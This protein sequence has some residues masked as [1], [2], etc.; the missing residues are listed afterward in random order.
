MQPLFHRVVLNAL[1]GVGL[2]IQKMS[3]HT[4]FRYVVHPLG[5]DLDLHPLLCRSRERAV[6]RLVAIGFGVMDPVPHTVGFRDIMAINNGIDPETFGR[7]LVAKFGVGHTLVAFHIKDDAHRVKVVYLVERDTLL[8]H[9]LPTR[10]DRLDTRHDSIVDA[11]G[12][13][14][15]ANGDSE[16]LPDFLFRACLFGKFSLYGSIFVGVGVLHHQL[17]KLGLD[18][19]EPEPMSQWNIDKLSLARYG[20]FLGVFHRVES[21]HIVETVT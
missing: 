16:A 20:K 15:L 4:L 8:L 1:V 7:L 14:I 11:S 13:K 17:L 21:S 9:L 10:I 12:I 5:T 2:F 6:E 19:V 3:R 18:I